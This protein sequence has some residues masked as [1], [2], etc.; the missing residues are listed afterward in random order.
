MELPP[1]SPDASVM[2]PKYLELI[3]HPDDDVENICAP[4][5]ISAE[6]QQHHSPASSPIVVANSGYEIPITDLILKATA[7][8]NESNFNRNMECVVVGDCKTVL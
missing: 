1:E 7:K 5:T 6:Q 2:K 8:L 3:Y 4:T